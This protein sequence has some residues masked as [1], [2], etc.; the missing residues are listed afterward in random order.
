[1]K[2]FQRKNPEKIV[3]QPRLE[4]WYE[5]NKRRGTLPKKFKD[6]DLI[7][8]YDELEASVRYF[9]HPL[10]IKYKKV[11]Y[12]IKEQ[13]N[14]V[15]ELWETPLGSLSRIHMRDE[16]GYSSAIKEFPIKNP[17]D[18]RILRY[19]FEDEEWYFDH[20][21]YER[22][23]ERIRDRGV[24]QFYFRR[25]PFQALMIDWMGVEKT[26]MLM[27]TD[28]E[29]LGEYLK[30]AE[31]ADNKMYDVLLSCPVKIL[32]LGENIDVRFDSPTIFKDYLFPYYEKRINQIHEAG[33]FVH[34]HVDGAF[35]QLIPYLKNMSLDGLEALTPKPQGDV[36]IEEIKRSLGDFIILDGIP[37]VY[38]LNYYPL[39]Q[40]M[41][42]IEKLVELFH[43]KLILGVSDEV[44]PDTD[45]ERLK[46]A[47]KKVRTLNDSL[48]NS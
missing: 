34:M 4:L 35:K 44:P 20:E 10:R 42:C 15:F 7:D 45:F 25:S 2:I 21:T 29:T 43:P 33:K 22:D 37:A 40:L 23:L 46:A 28:F 36:T 17:E 16:V 12:S 27:M 11:K 38:F 24:A 48:K 18:F 32:N 1:M 19:I 3:W 6:A 14:Q 31:E 13:K 9:T 30:F 39:E 5:Y 26:I 47:S 41:S 8:I